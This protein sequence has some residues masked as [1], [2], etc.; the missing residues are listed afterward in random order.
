MP[1]ESKTVGYCS[2]HQAIPLESDLDRLIRTDPAAVVVLK[3][4][5]ASGSRPLDLREADDEVEDRLAWL[6][7]KDPGGIVAVRSAFDRLEAAIERTC[8]AHSGLNQRVAFLEKSHSE[9]QSWIEA[10]WV[11]LGRADGTRLAEQLLFGNTRRASF[12]ALDTAFVRE[13]AEFFDEPGVLPLSP[14][15]SE[16]SVVDV[17][18][19]AKLCVSAAASHEMILIYG[20]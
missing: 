9:I 14:E 15:E 16:T 18:E 11:R 6:A 17:L 13:A 2:Y 12:A 20:N 4:F 7:E 1:E 3:D 10:R 19:L 5:W 8:D